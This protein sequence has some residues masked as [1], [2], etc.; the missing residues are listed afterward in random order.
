MAES[1]RGR[2]LVAQPG[3]EDPNFARTVV[4][5]VEHNA[6]GTLGVVLNRPSMVAVDDV[7]EDWSAVAGEPPVV[8]VGGPVQ[9]EVGICLARFVATDDVTLERVVG[10]YAIADLSRPPSEQ[11]IM[12]DARFFSGYSGWETA[13]LEWELALDSWFIVEATDADLNTRHP[14]DL[15]R[16]VLRRQEASL[17]FYADFP[18]DP[19]SN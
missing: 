1:Y 13:Q 9:P 17:A 16:T 3:M 7:L 5:I 6:D 19:G 12:A 8:F 14:A 4:L 2:L 18:D 10:E 15:W 11:G